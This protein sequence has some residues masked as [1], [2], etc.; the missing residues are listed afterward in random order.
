MRVMVDDVVA[1]AYDD[2]GRTYGPAHT[3][4]GSIG[5]RQMGHTGRCEYGHVTVYPLRP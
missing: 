3:H 5:L 4:A 2:E 1:V